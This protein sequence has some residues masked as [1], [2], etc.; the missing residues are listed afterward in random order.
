VSD[1]EQLGTVLAGMAPDD[2][3]L[4]AL[5]RALRIAIAIYRPDAIA[6]LGR[7][8]AALRPRFADIWRAVTTDLTGVARPGCRL[9]GTRSDLLGAIGAAAA[10]TWREKGAGAPGAGR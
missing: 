8:G 6:H 10:A 1:P 7:V 3:A 9:L 5:A 2:P 4:R